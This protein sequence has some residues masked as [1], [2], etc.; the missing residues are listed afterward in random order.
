MKV[1]RDFVTNSSSTSYIIADKT[2]KSRKITIK[3]EI[4]LLNMDLDLITLENLE[5]EVDERDIEKCKEI[6][7]NGGRIYR[8][9]CSSEADNP[10]E[11]YLHN[12]GI[13]QDAIIE[14]NIEV[15]EG[16]PW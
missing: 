2:G 14:D 9:I 16:E 10:T 5:D 11:L 15:I 3:V 7:K 4:D 6:L 13:Y 8:I 12:A 1:K